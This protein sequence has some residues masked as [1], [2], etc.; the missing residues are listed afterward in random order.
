MQHVFNT[1]TSHYPWGDLP[2]NGVVV[3]VGSG[4]GFVSVAIAQLHQNLKFVFQG[5]PS[6][7]AAAAEQMP[8]DLKERITFQGHD[9]LTPNPVK[10][11]DVYFFRFIFHNWSDP[12]CIRILQAL[13]PALKPGAVV[14]HPSDCYRRLCYSG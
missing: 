12:Y 5:L 2:K 7:I 6:T 8:A 14:Y 3:D 1:L 13:I 10:G 4:I 9:F 11:A